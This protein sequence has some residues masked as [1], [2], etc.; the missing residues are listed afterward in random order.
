VGEVVVATSIPPT[1]SRRN[2][3][4]EIGETYQRLCGFRVL[5]LNHA[6]EIPSLAA[7]YPGIE[8]IP[9]IR[10]ASSISGRKIPYIADLLSATLSGP[11]PVL[12]IVNADILFEPGQTWQR[13]LPNITRKI[14]IAGQR[15]DTRSLREGNLS[16]YDTG[17][18]RHGLRLL[19]FRS[20][21]RAGG[22]RRS[23][24]LCDRVGVVGLLVAADVDA[25]GERRSF[26][27]TAQ[28]AS[29]SA[30]FQPDD[31]L[32]SAWAKACANPEQPAGALRYWAAPGRCVLSCTLP[33]AGF[34][35]AG[36]GRKGRP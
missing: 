32:A 1:L 10:D 35:P 36:I 4:S 24:A 11:E 12:G 31:G 26:G 30:Q 19:L 25:Q 13:W 6:D 8:F 14:L 2:E 7:R 34:D 15:F 9:T 16:L 18:I 33:A 27:K 3:N 20:S 5:S 28:C 29:P 23:N 17:F 22:A 21:K